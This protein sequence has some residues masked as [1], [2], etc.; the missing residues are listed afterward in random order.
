M[1]ERHQ[2]NLI[3]VDDKSIRFASICKIE[4]Y[5]LEKGEKVVEAVEICSQS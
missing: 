3:F 1:D 2:T 4:D 5:L